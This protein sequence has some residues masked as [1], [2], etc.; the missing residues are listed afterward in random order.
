MFRKDKLV[1]LLGL[2]P[3][4]MQPVFADDMVLYAEFDQFELRTQGLALWDVEIFGGDVSDKGFVIKSA[5]EV[6][7]RR[8]GSHEVQVLGQQ[9]L[10]DSWALR[11]G[12]RSDNY[13]EPRRN[14]GVVS[15]VGENDWGTGFEVTGYANRRNSSLLIGAEHFHE[16][17]ERWKLIPKIEAVAYGDD[18]EETSIGRGLS[19]LEIG[20]RLRHIVTPDFKPY[21]GINWIT[22]FSRTRELLEAEG[23]RSRN[24]TLRAGFTFTI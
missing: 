12:L 16:I 20:I 19:T 8:L 24:F 11:S 21:V 4:L 15:L 23:S 9:M 6:P 22:S 13:P 1:L 5:A 10:N 18:D 2:L 17:A 3:T 7:N 14:W